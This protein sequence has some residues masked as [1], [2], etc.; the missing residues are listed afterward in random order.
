[1]KQIL[2]ACSCA[3]FLLLLV[4]SGESKASLGKDRDLCAN[5]IWKASEK[6][7]TGPAMAE[8]LISTNES[9]FSESARMAVKNSSFTYANKGLVKFP[10]P[11]SLTAR[12][13]LESN[14][15]FE[16]EGATVSESGA[17]KTSPSPYEC[18]RYKEHIVKVIIDEP[19]ST[20]ITLTFGESVYHNLWRDP[21]DRAEAGIDKD[22]QII[23]ETVTI[24]PGESSKD[25]VIR[26][27]DD[28]TPE[29]E[30]QLLLS[31]VYPDDFSFQL[32]T[33]T[34]QDDDQDKGYDFES[35]VD[36]NFDS[37]NMPSGWVPDESAFGAQWRIATASYDDS[38]AG[39]RLLRLQY[40]GFMDKYELID[41]SIES[42]A[43]DSRAFSELKL[44]FQHSL[45]VNYEITPP[46]AIVEIW[47]GSEW[48]NVWE[49]NRST[50]NPSWQSK[51]VEVSIPIDFVNE[52]TKIRFRL[53]VYMGAI[54]QIDQVK[55]SGAK[56]TI[57]IDE[58]IS[59][60]PGQE[61][62]G[63]N[64]TVFFFNPESKNILAKIK[65]LTAHDYGCTSVEIDRAGD[66]ASEWLSGYSISDKTLRVIPSNPNPEG[67]YEITLYYTAAELGEFASN[68]TSMGKSEG[69]IGIGD[70]SSSTAVP[71][72]VA[73]YND[74]YA[75]TA[76]FSTGFSGFG[77]SDAPPSG[78]LPVKLL[79]FE[80][81]N[82]NEGNML[83]WVTTEE[84][85]NDYFAVERSL[86]A[87]KFSE[88]SRVAGLTV[89]TNSNNYHFTDT[90]FVLG[91]NYYRLKQVDKDGKYAYS[92]TIA[93]NS[94]N[95]AGAKLYP[96]PVHAS[97][98]IELPDSRLKSVEVRIVNMLGIDVYKKQNVSLSAGKLSQDIGKLQPGIYQFV[99]SGAGNSYTF[100]I[101][102]Q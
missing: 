79:S 58:V 80:G 19:L 25:I 31:F 40:S 88:I 81:K 33:L 2:R 99:V 26:I 24:E 29:K 91:K 30:E 84:V 1:M 15:H 69:G 87:R 60:S 22:Y 11:K 21:Y 37:P 28:G 78:S 101:V 76:T 13:Q 96:N 17:D 45:Y 34:I 90:D 51:N 39:D 35:I 42:P 92:K 6:K 63:P 3:F 77:L 64:A 61:R 10:S 36:E 70:P 65:N 14:I 98:T 23:P 38:K 9:E 67:S 27:L 50:T 62:L 89:L 4:H 68:I 95:M 41:Q 47:T 8:K 54:W 16:L 85:N 82:T 48:K 97:V 86:D 59:T 83:N 20:P 94:E 66:G 7:S 53:W 72:T 102:K 73:K 18:I 52:H 100:P 5:V 57:P 32:Y 12:P 71:V 74:D 49:L 55:L 56:Y 46:R 93:I 75:F 44:S 43:F